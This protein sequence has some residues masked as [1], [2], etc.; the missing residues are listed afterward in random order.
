MLIMFPK[1]IQ[2]LAQAYTAVRYDKTHPPLCGG[3]GSGSM[4]MDLILSFN[5]L[6]G[7]I[8]AGVDV[9]LWMEAWNRHCLNS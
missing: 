6:C 8:E 7:N 2:C 4:F 9:D 3:G 1:L 5:P